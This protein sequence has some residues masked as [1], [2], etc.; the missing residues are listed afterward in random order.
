M[1]KKLLILAVLLGLVLLVIGLPVLNL[2]VRPPVSTALADARTGDPLYAKVAEALQPHCGSCHIRG[3]ALPFYAGL[4]VARAIVGED[5]R[6]GLE[7]YDAVAALAPAGGRPP[8]E[9]ALAKL[10][11]SI[12]NVTMPPQRYLA[13]HWD[14][15]LSAAQ[16][17]DVLAWVKDIRRRH[18]ATPGFPDAVQEAVIRPLPAS[19]PADTAKVALGKQLYHDKRL[20]GDDTLSCASCHDLAKGGTDRAQFST[21]IRGQKGDIN[22]PTTYNAGFHFVQFWDGRAATLQEQAAG[23]VAN[24]VEMGAEWPKVVEKLKADEAFAKAFAAAYPSGLTAENVQQAIAEFERTL[25]TPKASFDRFLAGDAKALSA[26][27]KQGY[28][29]F[30]DRAC[31]TCH[32]GALLGGGSFE[33]MGVVHDYFAE[34]GGTKGK[35]DDGR[36]N[37][38]KLESDRHRFKVPSLRNVA[39]TGPWFH[40]GTVTDLKKAVKV[41]ARVQRDVELS[42]ADAA[43]IVA[44]LGALTGEYEG[45]RLQ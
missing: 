40:D 7:S 36:F 28:D 19:V 39:L 42:D 13:L 5:V 26:E 8:S 21:G 3:A 30:I 10:E 16:R 43:K 20:S 45:K 32:A 29:L 44:F 24:P 25:V 15:S 38:T 11:Y 37:V 9:P 2:V 33:K 22:S 14:G 34:R 17:A 35:A 4:P 18:Y 6:A 1:K 23:P 41:M 12:V 31:A 27:E